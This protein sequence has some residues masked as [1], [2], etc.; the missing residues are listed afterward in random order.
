MKLNIKYHFR[1]L[2]IIQNKDNDKDEIGSDKNSSDNDDRYIFKV[3]DNE[4]SGESR[5]LEDKKNNL[6]GP[7]K[8]ISEIIQ[9]HKKEKYGERNMRYINK[10]YDGSENHKYSNTNENMIINNGDTLEDIGSKD[11]VSTDS[12]IDDEVRKV[13]VSNE[14]QRSIPQS[15]EEDDA[16]NGKGDNVIPINILEWG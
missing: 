4:S 11:M 13:S 16:E 15:P 7:L 9:K 6:Q 12:F 1:Q 5:L 8:E 3:K 2:Q 10:K 14:I